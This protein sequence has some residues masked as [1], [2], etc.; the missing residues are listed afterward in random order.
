M[1]DA[2][3][4]LKPSIRKCRRELAAARLDMG[5]VEVTAK[6][7]HGTG[8][9]VELVPGQGGLMNATDHRGC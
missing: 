9:L 3:Q 8:N 2:R 4:D 1:V 6:D 5:D 7:A